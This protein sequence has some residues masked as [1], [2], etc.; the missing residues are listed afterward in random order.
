MQRTIISA[1]DAKIS[2]SHMK[3]PFVIDM[4]RQII[5]QIDFIC[6]SSKTWFKILLTQ[7]ETNTSGIDELC[8]IRLKR[9]FEC[10][11]LDVG[12]R[13]QQRGRRCLRGYFLNK[14]IAMLTDFFW[15]W[16]HGVYENPAVV[17]IIA[18]CLTDNK[19]YSP[20]MMSY[21]TREV[22]L[23][24]M[25]KIHSYIILRKYNMVHTACVIVR[26]WC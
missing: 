16:Y 7:R 15:I 6:T 3:S 23:K 21:P 17:S 9:P 11:I 8:A 13:W 25:G 14:I 19:R 26:M 18:S 20:L 12:P 1:V 10:P 24:D 22:T 4:T 5:Y 2:P